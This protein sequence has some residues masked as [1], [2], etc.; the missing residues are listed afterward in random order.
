MGRRR[1]KGNPLLGAL[2][3]G[4]ILILV[5]RGC[6]PSTDHQPAYTPPNPTPMSEPARKTETA[7]DEGIP[8]PAPPI[9]PPQPP[10][11][12]PALDLAVQCS[13]ISQ[14]GT[15]CQRMTKNASGI[16]WQ[17]QGR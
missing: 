7:P 11:P 6:G 2:I 15:R 8:P 5:C 17:H 4:V 12:G 10:E 13:G 3:V 1:K 16:C 9:T 14:D